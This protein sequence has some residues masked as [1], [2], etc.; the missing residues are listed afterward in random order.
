MNIIEKYN[1]L[2]GKKL[3]RGEIRKLI[4]EAIKQG[5]TEIENKLT[6]LLK[7]YPGQKGFEFEKVDPIQENFEG[8]GI[9][10]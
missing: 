9:P 6:G 2:E 7:S 3:Y 1:Q 10:Y 5:E 4:N 8:L